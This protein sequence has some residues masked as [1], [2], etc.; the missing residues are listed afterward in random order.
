MSQYLDKCF[1]SAKLNSLEL[2]NR[3]IKAATFEGMSAKGKPK[4]S[5]GVFHSRLAEGGIGMTTLAYCGAESN[6]RVMD[7]M[8]YMDEQ[9]KPQLQQIISD[10]HSHGAKVSGQLSHCGHF[11]KNKDFKGRRPLGPSFGIN[12][13]GIASGMP[14]AGALTIPQI[15]ERVQTF[16]RAALFM[17]QT[18][19]D[20]IEIHFGHGY[21]ISQFISPRTNKRK[22]EYGGSLENRMRFALEVLAAVRAAVGDDF[23]ILGKISMMDGVG[24]GIKIDDAVEIAKMLDKGGIDGIITSGGTSSMNPMLMFRGDTLL[25]GMIEQEQNPLM[26]FGLKL[27][28]P[29]LF[30]QYPYQDTY[31]LPEAQRIRDAVACAVVY[32]GG[33]NSNADIERVMSAGFDFIQLGRSLIHDPDFVKHAM[34]DVNYKNGCS[35]CNKCAT[36]IEHPDGIRCVEV[37]LSS[38]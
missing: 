9:I 7:S 13:V 31:F 19:F 8:L 24:D 1:S 18:G 38:A 22:D 20:A 2:R 5:L 11:S 4:D 26:R 15:K 28:G 17:Q 6:G 37:P 21:G 36:L 14:F 23:P 12:S 35:H 32:I 30:R 25:N 10:V 27:V 29:K 33:C 3:I 16:A 34:A